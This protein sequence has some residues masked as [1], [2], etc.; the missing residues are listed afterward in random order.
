MLNKKIQFQKSYRNKIDLKKINFKKKLKGKRISK[1]EDFKV[2]PVNSC[3]GF[4]AIQKIICS[5]DGKQLFTF[6]RNLILIYSLKTG[7]LMKKIKE[8]TNRITG[9]CLS[10]NH[11]FRLY[12]CSLDK[13]ICEW[14]LLRGICVNKIFLKMK[15]WKIISGKN[16]LMLH[17]T[18]KQKSKI[19]FLDFKS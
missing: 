3:N 18:I 14:D 6:T 8:H 17:G 10:V 19:I 15:L 5:K 11:P 1:L 13:T 9:I 7:F 4:I 12:S 16:R 2:F